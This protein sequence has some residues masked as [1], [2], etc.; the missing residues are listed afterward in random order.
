MSEQLDF[1]DLRKRFQ[2]QGNKY[3]IIN[4]HKK[5]CN[6]FGEPVIWDDY[7]LKKKDNN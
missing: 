3:E 4:E 5:G 7:V 6:R 1:R 2:L